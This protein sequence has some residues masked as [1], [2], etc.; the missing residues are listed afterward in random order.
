MSRIEPSEAQAW[1]EDT[2]LP[3]AEFDPALISQVEAW[4][5]G[6]L[7]T[8]FDTTTWVD[9]VTTPELVR[10]VIAMMYVHRLYNRAY[11]GDPDNMNDYAMWLRAEALNLIDGLI[12][13][14]IVMDGI[15]VPTTGDPSFYPNDLSSSLE[16]DYYDKSLGDA[17]F[18]TG[19]KF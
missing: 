8:A 15:T 16:P 18:N 17:K 6:K 3:L 2:K 1:S 10:Q 4:V 13:G 5:M 11:S 14:S 19:G 12:A 9:A 7:A